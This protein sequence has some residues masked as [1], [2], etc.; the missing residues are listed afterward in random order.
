MGN[1]LAA[2]S[3]ILLLLLKPLNLA[4]SAG[5]DSEGWQFTMLYSR[6]SGL[7]GTEGG[8]EQHCPRAAI[9][10]GTPRVLCILK[11]ASSLGSAVT[12]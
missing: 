8:G 9:P 4:E 5:S 6:L 7:R 12:A 2:W 10:K 1:A 3:T 11:A